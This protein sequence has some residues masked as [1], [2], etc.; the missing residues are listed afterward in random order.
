MQFFIRTYRKPLTLVMDLFIKPGREIIIVG[1]DAS[2]QNTEYWNRLVMESGQ[3]EFNL[4]QSPEKLKVLVFDV[5]EGDVPVSENYHLAIKKMARLELG[6][7]LIDDDTKEFIDFARNF[8]EKSGYTGP[9]N[10]YS[11]NKKFLIRYLPVIDDVND[12]P[13]RIHKY[14]GYIEVSKKWFD[15]MTI[16][17]RMAIL[18]HE[19]AHNHLEDERITDD[20]EIEKEADDNALQI[21]KALGYPRV[22]WMYAWAHIFKDNDKHFDRLV[23]SDINLQRL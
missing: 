6:S 21:Y 16:P 18:T 10:Y 7:L 2:R 9:G 17:G 13:S 12:T 20:H 1:M 11:K 3:Y 14:E 8:A 15:G 19:F 5:K 22:E 23:N 4:P